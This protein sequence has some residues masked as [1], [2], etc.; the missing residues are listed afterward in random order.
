MKYFAL[1]ML[2]A[3]L[4]SAPPAPRK[5]SGNASSSGK[6]I[7]QDAG[8]L[9]APLVAATPPTDKQSGEP[10]SDAHAQET[11]VIRESAPVPKTNKDGWDKAPVILTGV[12]VVVGALGVRAAFRTLK[13]IETQATVMAEQRQVMFGQ[14]RTMQ[15]QITEMS[16]QS[17]ILK[18]SV[19]VSRDAAKAAQDG[20]NAAKESADATRDSVETFISKE[21]ARL[22]IT[23]KPLILKA[24]TPMIAYTVRFYGQTEAFITNSSYYG[25]TASAVTPKLTKHETELFI[26]SLPDV[27]GPSTTLQAEYWSSIFN[28]TGLPNWIDAVNDAEL[29]IYFYLSIKYKTLDKE[30]ETTVFCKWDVNLAINTIIGE[31]L[32]HW[33]PVGPP[34]ANRET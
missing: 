22:R 28:H 20:A 17:G 12:L 18:E 27:I 2:L 1:A 15:E 7:K 13:A 11:I 34:E 5:A 29:F 10:P 23:L 32:D 3:V 16:V 33:A 30:R 19:A 4:Q 9:Q 26:V 21:R 31:R 14:L 24:Q 25:F 8:N 6:S